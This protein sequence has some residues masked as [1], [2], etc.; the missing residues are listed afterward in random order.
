MLYDMYC[1]VCVGSRLSFVLWC[2]MFG[3]HCV[4]C[5]VCYVLC[6]GLR[7]MGGLCGMLFVVYGLL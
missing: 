2:S 7:M 4:L 5:G 1:L 3:V 6:A